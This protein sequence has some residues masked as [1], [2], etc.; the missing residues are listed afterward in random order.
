M[1]FLLEKAWIT[2]DEQDQFDRLSPKKQ[3]K[4]IEDLLSKHPNYKYIK[5]AAPFINQLIQ[6]KGFDD[7]DNPFLEFIDNVKNNITTGMAYVIYKLME[8]DMLDPDDSWLYTDPLYNESDE[9]NQYKLKAMAYATRGSQHNASRQVK[10]EELMDNRGRIY[11]AKTIKSILSKISVRDTS[12]E[13]SDALLKQYKNKINLND[14]EAVKKKLLQLI[15]NFPKSE[16]EVIE[17]TPIEAL[18]ALKTVNEKE[19]E[20]AIIKTLKAFARG[21]KSV[22]TPKAR[23][24]QTSQSKKTSTPDK[25]ES[26]YAVNI[27]KNYLKDDSLSWDELKKFIKDVSSSHSKSKM[28]TDIVD[29]NFDAI[30]PEVRKLLTKKITPI[31]GEQPIDVVTTELLNIFDEYL[32]VGSSK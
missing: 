16:Y 23:S 11:S 15:N 9:D 5:D 26:D 24:L 3:F 27:I 22:L 13:L 32:T 29:N 31:L 7:L 20:L 30:Q 10:P 25:L 4:F 6:S 28:I 2:P 8:S 21:D 19:T 14:P 12:K 18:L 17:S 1:K